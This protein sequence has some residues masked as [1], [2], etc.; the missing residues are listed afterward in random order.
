M[1]FRISLYSFI[2]GSIM[3]LIRTYRRSGKIRGI[4]KYTTN[5]KKTCPTSK[6]TN[7]KSFAVS[8]DRNSGIVGERVE[9]RAKIY[10]Y[11]YMSDRQKRLIFFLIILFSLEILARNKIAFHFQITTTK[12]RY[13][14]TFKVRVF[15]SLSR[16]D[17]FTITTQSRYSKKRS[18]LW[19][20][21][22]YYC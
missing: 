19:G 13:L 10:I 1:A 15:S 6:C 4:E 5:I 12:E 18:V 22:F 20:R 21:W 8:C 7:N 11:I 2:S 16:S 14:P 3:R 17:S 9:M